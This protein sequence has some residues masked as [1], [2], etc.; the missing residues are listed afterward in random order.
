LESPESWPSSPLD[1]L[2]VHHHV[3]LNWATR[4]LRVDPAV[5]D[6]AIYGL[7][8]AMQDFA[9]I[10]WHC[11]RLL[12][13]EITA[14]SREGMYLPNATMLARRVDAAVEAGLLSA[15]IGERF[16][17]KNQAHETNRAGKIWLC[18]FPPRI[19]GEGGVGDL[20]RFWGGEALYN[21]HDR[22]PETCAILKALGTP[23]IVEAEIPVAYLTTTFPLWIVREDERRDTSC[24]YSLYLSNISLSNHIY[25]VEGHGLDVTAIDV[26]FSPDVEETTKD[27]KRA[28]S[29][30][31]SVDRDHFLNADV[32]SLGTVEAYL[33]GSLT[34]D[35][36]QR[37]EIRFSIKFET[38]RL[39]REAEEEAHIL[40]AFLTLV[41]HGFV[42]PSHL[43]LRGAEGHFFNLVV[44]RYHGDTEPA[45]NSHAS[46]SLMLPDQSGRVRPRAAS[47]VSQ[48]SGI[49]A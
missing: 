34:S 19:A 42:A 46:Y 15:S 18:F 3:F 8:D 30:F 36:G 33:A 21:A 39:L 40:C 26:Q 24:C 9:V 48:Q 7:M 14:I 16:K 1:Y 45:P 22:E 5:Y 38:P 27:F 37:P 23:T 17:L 6:R 49:A 32:P 41:S 13:Y 43:S 35:G 28:G 11:T 44:P 4:A 29:A 47:V 12:D 10:G 20:F 25:I 31:F 2:A